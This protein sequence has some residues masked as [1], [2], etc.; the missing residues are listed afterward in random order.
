MISFAVESYLREEMKGRADN[1]RCNLVG[2]T[3]KR[4]NG[5]WKKVLRLVT[6]RRLVFVSGRTNWYLEEPQ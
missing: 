1:V 4:K 3:K 6:N 2:N 5:P